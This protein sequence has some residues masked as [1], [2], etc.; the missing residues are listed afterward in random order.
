MKI[1]IVASHNCGKYSSFVLE[2]AGAIERLKIE[3][4]YFPVE[5]KGVFGYLKNRKK[6]LKKIEECHP[7]I[8]HAHYGLSGLLANLQRKIPVVTTFHGSDI[9][10][11]GIWLLLSKVCMN[12]SAFNIFVSKS[13]YEIAKYKKDNYKILPCGADTHTFFELSKN[14]ARNT[15]GWE[16]N[17]KYV[18]FAGAFE[19]KVKNYALAQ[20]AAALLNGCR[21]IEL[22]GYDRVQ[23]N[24]L[25]N[26]CDCLLMTSEREAS[27]MVIKEALLCGCPIVSVD[28]GDVKEMILG[29]NGCYIAC[30]D[31]KSIA[32]K[33]LLA[34][35][36][37]GK[38]DGRN[39]VIQS[40]L[41]LSV[42]AQRIQ[43]VYE[44]VDKIYTNNKCHF[45]R[46]K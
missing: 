34:F 44:K 8:I 23:V 22:K 33:L 41:D 18:L 29:I 7:N 1:L 2:Q 32:D 9:H 43:S 26:A 45:V 25:M 14:E 39:R 6:L 19:N 46:N 15:L 10:S 36:F 17:G 13:I 28:V 20:K 42:V 3:I 11:K 12:L 5:G 37:K 27:P 35:E 38:T 16:Q 30:R 40:G 4:Y 24:L 21:L 31:P